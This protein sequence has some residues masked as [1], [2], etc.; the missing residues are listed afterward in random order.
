MRH[1]DPILTTKIYTDA[2]MLPI[3]DAVGAL[4]MFNDTQIDTQKLDSNGQTA[5][6]T[7][8]FESSIRNFLGAEDK[9]LSPLEA[10]SVQKSPESEIGSRGR[11]RRFLLRCLTRINRVSIGNQAD[12]PTTRANSF[13]AVCWQFCWQRNAQ[14]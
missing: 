4:P 1:S 3:W 8:P 5:P 9:T 7:V 2:G 14:Q 13:T 11:I 10:G 12:S 6:P